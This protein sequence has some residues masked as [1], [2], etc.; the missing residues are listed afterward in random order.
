MRWVLTLNITSLSLRKQTISL[1]TLR[2]N[3]VFVNSPPDEAQYLEETQNK[4]NK[5]KK[6]IVVY[7]SRRSKIKRELLS[8]NHLIRRW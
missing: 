5:E 3:R 2:Q 1:G 4:V 7:K 6:Q 8:F